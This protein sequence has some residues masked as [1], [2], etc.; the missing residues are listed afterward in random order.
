[1]SE[2]VGRIF[3]IPVR[4]NYAELALKPRELSGQVRDVFEATGVIGNPKPG[5]LLR[6]RMP[7]CLRISTQT[8][9]IVR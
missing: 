9:L 6:R 7:P 3:G 8:R 1:M 2:A 5:P 4:I